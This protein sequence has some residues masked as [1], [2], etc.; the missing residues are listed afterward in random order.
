M[1]INVEAR[2]L[3]IAM[4]LGDGTIGLSG[5][6]SM[7]HCLSQEG[8]ISWKK[9][10]LRSVGINTT[11]L[12]QVQNNG[13]GGYEL[14]T[15]THNFLKLYR[16]LMY[17]PTKTITRKLLDKLDVK[18]LAV[19]YMDDGSVSQIKGEDGSI[20]RTVMTISTC[21]SREQNQIFIDYLSEVWGVRFGQRKMKNHFA[22][23]CSTKEARKFIS[24]V[25]PVVNQVDCMKYKL[26]VKS[27]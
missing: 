23:V 14:R 21:T 2:N 9:D 13:Y 27:E 5:N 6:L 20:K 26:K 3:C 12:Y 4:A 7:R 25:S 11:E 10:Q 24:I 15:Y 8:Y 19:W 17:T 18:G 1:S 22:L 16:K